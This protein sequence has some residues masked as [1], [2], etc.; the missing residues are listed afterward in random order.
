MA[1][2]SARRRLGAPASSATRVAYATGV[3]NE[4]QP[5]CT[6]NKSVRG[7]LEWHPR[8][9]SRRWDCLVHAIRGKEGVKMRL[10]WSLLT[11]WGLDFERAQ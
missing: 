7:L 11:L 4:N 2:V 5:M 1:T 9:N 10:R 8:C 6:L 3:I